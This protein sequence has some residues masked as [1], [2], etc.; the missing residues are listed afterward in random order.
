MLKD[1]SEDLSSDRETFK[2]QVQQAFFNHSIDSIGEVLRRGWIRGEIR[3]IHL[4]L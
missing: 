2:G 3:Q 4:K 1:V